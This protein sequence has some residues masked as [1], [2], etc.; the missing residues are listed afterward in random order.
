MYDAAAL[1][2]LH[3]YGRITETT[4]EEEITD[5]EER[6]FQYF[7]G[8]D[9]KVTMDPFRRNSKVRDALSVRFKDAVMNVVNK[10]KSLH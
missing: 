10:I 7:D 4:P 2:I 6:L 5:M 9:F 3:R 1:D 8:G